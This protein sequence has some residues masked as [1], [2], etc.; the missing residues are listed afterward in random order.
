MPPSHFCLKVV[1]AGFVR[2]EEDMFHLDFGW[3]QDEARKFM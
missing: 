2:G 1:G 3:L